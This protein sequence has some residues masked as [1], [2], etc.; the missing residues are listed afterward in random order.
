MALSKRSG[1]SLSVK[2]SLT[3]KVAVKPR[4]TAFLFARA[5][6]VVEEVNAGDF[7]A[8]S[9]EEEGN[10]ARAAAGVENG[11]RYPIG[12]VDKRLLR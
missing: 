7:L 3:K 5:D 12:G 6:G 1:M 10:L 2:A 4:S 11:A 9:C 8:A